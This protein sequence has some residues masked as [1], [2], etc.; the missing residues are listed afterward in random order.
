M[1]LFCG[2]KYIFYL[3][4]EITFLHHLTLTSKISV[5]LYITAL[6]LTFEPNIAS[7]DGT[8]YQNEKKR[9]ILTLE[10]RVNAIK[11]HN[12]GEGAR[13]IAK[14]IYLLSFLCDPLFRDHLAEGVVSDDRF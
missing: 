4:L 13:S 2:H 7:P 3:Y 10:D 1:P 12:T 14:G 8:E 11:R 5:Q 6:I 9:K